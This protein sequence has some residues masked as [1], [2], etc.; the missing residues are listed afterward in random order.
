MG[1]G[2][3]KVLAAGAGNEKRSHIR[4][5]SA[6]YAAFRSVYRHLHPEPS[7]GGMFAA[8]YLFSMSGDGFCLCLV[9]DI[10]NRKAAAR[11]VVRRWMR[12]ERRRWSPIANPRKLMRQC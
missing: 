9:I 11:G 10:S 4:V 8:D 6:Q 1:T 2:T 12:R 5:Y 7:V 3:E